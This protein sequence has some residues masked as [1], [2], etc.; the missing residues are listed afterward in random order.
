MKRTVIIILALTMLVPSLIS[1]SSKNVMEYKGYEL[2]EEMYRYW[3]KSWKNYYIEK[4]SDVTDT[5]EFWQAT[6]IAGVTNEAYI[7]EQIETR[8][9]YYLIAQKLFEE[10]KLTLDDETKDKIESDIGDQTEHYG[11]KS[12]FND[13]L[14]EEY[15]INISTLRKIYYAEEKYTAVYNY[16][17]NNTNGIHT[18]TPDELDAYYHNY[19][20]RVKY[21][22]FF[23]NVKYAYDDEGKRITD[24]STGYY[25]FI[26]L[27]DEEKAEVVNKAEEV[28]NGLLAG[29]NIDDYMV[30]YM[31][32][33][34]FDLSLYP[35]GFYISAD[36][37][38]SH[39]SDVTSAALEM[40]PGEVRKIENDDYYFIVQKF[41]LIDKAYSK[42]PDSE[43]FQYLVSYSN[44]EKFS[45]E[46]NE[47]A[48]DIKID[49]VLK[50]KYS[51]SKI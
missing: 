6:S 34:E 19:Y 18:S 41:E 21:V 12:E 30:K 10:Y 15:G 16:L 40:Q 9:K 13:Y 38:V 35:N 33:F 28:Y 2:T 26:D 49:E 29:E 31:D 24:P 23:K 39:T 4:F 37:Y 51:L 25:S 43:Q 7:T 8:I 27:T 17:Y 14:K 50:K 3:M 1:C 11:S 44:N 22:M 42:T 45:V 20:A 47:Y 32:E 46:F 48:K 5:E 36:D